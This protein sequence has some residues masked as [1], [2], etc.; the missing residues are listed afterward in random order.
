MFATA[1]SF[2]AIASVEIAIY[3][4]FGNEV[5]VQVMKYENNSFTKFGFGTII[6]NT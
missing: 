3:C 4:I 6:N 2:F 5:I 1:A